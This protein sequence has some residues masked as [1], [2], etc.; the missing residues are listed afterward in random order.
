MSISPLHPMTINQTVVA[1]PQLDF[2]FTRRSLRPDYVGPSPLS[3]NHVTKYLYR[4][5][6]Y[7]CHTMAHSAEEVFSNV[8]VPFLY[9]SLYQSFALLWF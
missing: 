4:I 6:Y 1:F 7:I 8:S 3:S 9:S 5:Q 2:R